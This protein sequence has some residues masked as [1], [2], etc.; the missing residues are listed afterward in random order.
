M[1]ESGSKERPVVE[2]EQ[3]RCGHPACRT[4]SLTRVGQF[5]VGCGFPLEQA[6]RIA[7]LIND[8]PNFP[9]EE[10]D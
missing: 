5:Y 10:Y 4:Y 6:Q 1:T 3:C 9:F 2:I 8:D 7:D